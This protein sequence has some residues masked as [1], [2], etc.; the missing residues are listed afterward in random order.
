MKP[1]QPSAIMGLY[2]QI[3][4]GTPDAEDFLWLWGCYLRAVDDVIDDEKWDSESVLSVL[5]LAC[6]FYSH[7]FYVRHASTL[8]MVV[9]LAT[10]S[11]ADSVK[12][13]RANEQWK[14][15]WADVLRHAGNEVIMA[16]AMICG[17]WQAMRDISSPLMAMCYVYHAD[18]HGVPGRPERQ[19][20]ATI[21]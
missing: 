11:W 14:R 10:N 13:E 6:S 20:T 21:K 4:N 12:W 18:K 1:D 9:M 19:L 16:T 7:P 2:R 5:V 17:N 3:A 8:Q 15:E